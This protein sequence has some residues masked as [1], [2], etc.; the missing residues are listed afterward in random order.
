MTNFD[1][2][3]FPIL[4][5]ER[6]ILRQINASDAVDLLSMNTD[7]EVLKY[8]VDPPMKDISVAQAEIEKYRQS[9]I[10][11]KSIGWSACLMSSDRLIGD[12]VFFFYDQEIPYY[13]ADLGYRLAQPYWRQGY[14]TEALTAIIQFAFNVMKLHRINVDTRMD[15]IA[16]IRLMEKV[17]FT[18]EG[19]RRECVRNVDG[20]YQSWGLYGLLEQDYIH[21]KR[22]NP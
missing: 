22:L 8:D 18:H 20:S 12:F 17:G 21:R 16:S 1:F 15:N 13:K 2:S 5:T 6:L 14:A 11:K 9:F 10:D 19:V 7:P 4:T 3:S